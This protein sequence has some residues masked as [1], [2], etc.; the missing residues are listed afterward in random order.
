MAE[1]DAQRSSAGEGGSSWQRVARS[2]WPKLIGPVT[3]AQRLKGPA[4][5]LGSIPQGG[6][7]RTLQFG[8]WALSLRYNIRAAEP[9]WTFTLERVPRR[10]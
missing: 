10:L 3:E 4:L 7:G 2:F 1:A 6:S 9:G 5:G 8:G